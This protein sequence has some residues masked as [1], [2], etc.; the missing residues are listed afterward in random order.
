MGTKRISKVGG[1]EVIYEACSVCGKAVKPEHG[2]RVDG[3]CVR[4]I[5]C[6]APKAKD[7]VGPTI[8]TVPTREGGDRWDGIKM[9]S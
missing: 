1:A 6:M 3:N 2:F 5:D 9:D 7:K 4:H 8:T